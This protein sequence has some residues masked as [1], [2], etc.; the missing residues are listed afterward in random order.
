MLAEQEVERLAELAHERYRQWISPD[1]VAAGR[2]YAELDESARAANRDSVR[3]MTTIARALGYVVAEGSVNGAVSALTAD[4]IEVGAQLEHL[5]WERFTR[6]HG[7]SG[8]P[9]LV[10]WSELDEPTRDLDRMRVRDIPLLLAEVGL[11][12]QRPPASGG[13]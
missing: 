6:A 1:S 2:S 5:R 10:P 9:S 8:H 3:F 12:L 4:E 7:R 13:Q 11:S